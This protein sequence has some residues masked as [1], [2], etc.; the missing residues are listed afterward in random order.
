LVEL[1]VPEAVG[2]FLLSPLSSFFLIRSL[3]SLVGVTKCVAQVVKSVAFVPLL[4]VVVKLQAMVLLK[5][6]AGGR[7][8]S[9]PLNF[10]ES[11]ALLITLPNWQLISTYLDFS[12][13]FG[14]PGRNLSKALDTV[15]PVCY[16]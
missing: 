8:Q 7:E 13:E 11:Y 2:T 6:S 3:L 9:D 15:I 10:T 4:V 5:L 14:D 1:L 16:Q 12:E